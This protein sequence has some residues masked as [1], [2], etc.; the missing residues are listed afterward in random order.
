VKDPRGLAQ[1]TIF[2][3]TQREKGILHRD[4]KPDLRLVRQALADPWPLIAEQRQFR[5]DSLLQIVATGST[6]DVLSAISVVIDMEWRNLEC[7]R[8]DRLRA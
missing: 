3:H 7:E 4:G 8:L 6:R 5:V 1:L 2:L